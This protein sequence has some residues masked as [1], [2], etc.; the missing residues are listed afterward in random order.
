MTDSRNSGLTQ[1][2][3]FSTEEKDAC[4]VG[5]VVDRKGQASSEIVRSALKALKCVEHRGACGADRVTGDGAGI[6]ADIP[7]EMFGYQ[8]GSV[9]VATLFMPRSAEKLRLGLKV[10]EETFSFYGL[11]ILDYRD[12][13]VDTSCLGSEALDSLPA[14]QHAI[15]ERPAHCR[16]DESFN[17]LLYMAKQTSRTR[18]KENGL[19]SE[20]FFTSLSTTTI[21]YK[22]LTRAQD[23]DRFYLDLNDPAFKSRFALFHRRFS[24]NTRTS[25]DK[26]QPFRLIAHNGEINTVAGNRSWAFAREHALG[27]RA[28][29][30][31]TH[32]GISD[33]GSLNEMV[34]ALK[35]RSS[36][37]NV[38]D[39]L[40]IMIP[41]ADQ[42]NSFYKFWS[43]A[44]EPWDGPAFITFSDGEK[45]GARLDRNGFRPCRW[46]MTEDKFY[47]SSEAGA[48]EVDESIIEAKGTLRA[49][50]GVSVEI[51]NGH[52]HFEDPSRSFDNHDARFDA[53]LQKLEF[54]ARPNIEPDL[55][56]QSLFSYTEE[57]REKLLIP[58]ILEGKEAIG[59]MGD[60]ARL[61]IF[62]D[63]P[64]SFFDYFYQD[65]AQVTNPPLDYLRESMVT[66]L[67]IYL[68]KRPNIF[69]TKEL[70]PPP[71]ALELPSPVIS[72]GQIEY[73]RK[74]A[75]NSPS[76]GYLQ[77]R[78]L[79][80]TFRRDHA[81][82]GFRTQLRK[83]AEDAVK[84]VRAGCSILI[85][86]DRL[87]DFD[88]PPIPSL[89]VLRAVSHA[90]NAA[91]ELLEA[92]IVVDTG[93][94]R[95]AHQLA[96]LVS[97]GATAVSPY[98][99]FQI[100]CYDQDKDL[101][102]LN[103]DQKEKNLVKAFDS[104]LLRIMSKIGISV[105]RSYHG[106]RL[107]TAL[108][109]G[110]EIVEEYFSGIASPVGGIGIK[111]LVAN[112]LKQTEICRELQ[113]KNKYPV[114]HFNEYGTWLEGEEEVTDYAK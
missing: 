80:T 77:A 59:S 23:L 109:L 57:D 48:F 51:Q 95:T 3:P 104:G 72:L 16:T 19:V 96:T 62:S 58:M 31:L 100:A 78:E 9:A 98:L 49:G 43:R 42:N 41:P 11:K 111:Q 73:L 37:P 92:S 28:D 7:F 66:D 30:L 12:V 21:V 75:D 85:L 10:F 32:S 86:T 87:A 89:L 103:P 2:V 60:T 114:R 70:L 44:M 107:F 106:A 17:Q 45:I 27:L 94:V 25:W 40:A 68:G 6:M 105:V 26:A 5:F 34:E 20:F 84:A 8:K 52:I 15:I 46:V 99:A 81:E 63:E 97:F 39:I 1:A 79:H 102:K 90:L 55:S 18:H 108:G 83:L 110:K 91:G 67:S 38:E 61:A 54:A 93:E 65:F 53:H 14:I 33:S 71:R 35:Y 74:L 88:N 24:T 13:P 4:G 76:S 112:I 29:E 56:R 22:G 82:V 50:S 36:I 47:L 64:R 101:Q 113:D 69:S